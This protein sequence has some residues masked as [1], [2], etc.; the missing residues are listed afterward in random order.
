MLS[1]A[2]HIAHKIYSVY[3]GKILCFADLD[4]RWFRGGSEKAG[5][6]RVI[7]VYQSESSK[8][9]INDLG[10]EGIRVTCQILHTSFL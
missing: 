4:M 9:S 3:F 7:L 10:K 8:G 1:V 5:R 6:K 2:I